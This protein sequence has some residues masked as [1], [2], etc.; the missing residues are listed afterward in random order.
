MLRD[1]YEQVLETLRKGGRL[2]VTDLVRA[3]NDGSSIPT[4]GV[5]R[6]DAEGNAVPD[7]D[8]LTSDKMTN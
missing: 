6:Y 8:V 7:E 2:E 1:D 4:L 5:I 3:G